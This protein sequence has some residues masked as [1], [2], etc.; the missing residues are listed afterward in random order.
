MSNVDTDASFISYNIAELGDG[1][2]PLAML[3]ILDSIL[4]RMSRNRAAGRA[5]FVYIDEIHLLFRNAETAAWIKSL[6]KTARKYRCAPL[7]I[8]QDVEDLLS[9]DSG[10]SLITNSAFV[11]LLKQQAI[12][13]AVLAEQLQLSD[14]Q[15]E[16]VTDSPA[17]EG[18]LCIQNATKYTGGVIPFEDHYPEES[19]LYKIC[20]TTDMRQEA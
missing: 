13:A 11:V 20:Q 8:T 15:L 14:R 4:N 7:G 2:R 16:F 3:V 6:W 17:G 19:L 12:N 1:V 18:L 9:T 5:T 10:R